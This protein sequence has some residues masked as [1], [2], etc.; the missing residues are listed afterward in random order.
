MCKFLIWEVIP[1]N[2]S[3]GLGEGN[4]EEGKANTRVHSG[5]YPP[6]WANGVQSKYFLEVMK[7]K[8]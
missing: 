3:R 6:L 1:R 7:L 8:T 5:V 4:G 2:R